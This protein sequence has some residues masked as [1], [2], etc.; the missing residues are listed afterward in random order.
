M[1]FQLTDNWDHK[2]KYFQ[3]D[4]MKHKMFRFGAWNTVVLGSYQQGWVR[5]VGMSLLLSWLQRWVSQERASF[6]C[7]VHFLSVWYTCIAS[8]SVGFP[9]DVSP[10]LT[11]PL[12]GKLSYPRFTSRKMRPVTTHAFN[13]WQH[14]GIHWCIWDLAGFSVFALTCQKHPPSVLRVAR[15]IWEG[16][17]VS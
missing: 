4:Y 12:D 7:V 2:S 3:W 8:I 5:S 10:L 17:E 16:A 9:S 11:H 6:W 1:G 13:Y 15:E 14:P